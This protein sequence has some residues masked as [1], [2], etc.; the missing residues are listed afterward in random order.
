MLEQSHHMG[1]Y[2][3]EEQTTVDIPYGNVTISLYT[4]ENHNF[5]ANVK[6]HYVTFLMYNKS[7]KIILMVQCHYVTSV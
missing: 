7:F 3:S 4:S 1:T 6:Q 2:V 5:R